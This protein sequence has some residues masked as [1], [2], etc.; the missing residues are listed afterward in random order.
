MDNEDR[1]VIDV[2]RWQ[3]VIDWQAVKDSGVDGAWI[4]VGGND[5]GKYTDSQAARNMSEATRLGVPFGTYYFAV[6]QV[7]NAREIA[8]H[9]VGVGHG[10]GKLWPALDLESNQYG[11]TNEQLDRW[12]ME[13]CHEVMDLTG[14]DGVLY[15]GAYFGVGHEKVGHPSCPLWI[16]NYGGNRPG[17]EPPGAWEPPVPKA[18]REEGWSAW[19]FNSVTS[20]PGISGNVDQNTVK[21]EFWDQMMTGGDGDTG[22]DDM[23]MTGIVRTKVGSAWALEHIGR[24]DVSA[25]L[26]TIEGNRTVRWLNGEALDVELFW[27]G[28]TIGEVWEV[29]DSFL[30]WPRYRFDDGEDCAD[31]LVEN[32]GTV[33]G[34]ITGEISGTFIPTH[35]H[36]R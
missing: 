13:F 14:R 25:Y 15:T 32:V 16:A 24:N 19:Q 17:T 8:L 26:L 31:D 34:S 36:E 3:G 11:L 33:A 20:V 2:S 9:A 18:W 5:A 30:T 28:K 22:E 23:A 6:P 10:Q 7:D 21:A 12:V 27:A 4:K 1:W 29:E 35:D